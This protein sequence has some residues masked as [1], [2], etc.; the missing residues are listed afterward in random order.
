MKIDTNTLIRFLN[1]DLPIKQMDEIKMLIEKNSKIKLKFEEIK[2]FKD[3]F[4][5]SIK[6][7]ENMK[8]PK[9][10]E[11]KLSI[12]KKQFNKKNSIKKFTNF[13]KIAAG[14]LIIISFSVIFLLPNKTYL[15]ENPITQIKKENNIQLFYQ[16]EKLNSFLEENNNCSKPEEFIDENGRKI[17]AVSCQK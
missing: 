2:S 17:Y 15:S 6:N 14:V 13:Y 5:N 3:N 11:E 1:R 9:N 4:K 8:M 7:I 12:Q 10:L 16:E